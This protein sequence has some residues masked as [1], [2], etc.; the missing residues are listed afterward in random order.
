[1]NRSIASP[2][3]PNLFIVGAPKCGT[4][5]WAEYL[6]S[7][8]DIFFPQHKDQCFFALDLPNF[9]LTRTEADYAELFA[10]SG[11]ASV[12]GEASAMYLFSEVAA[13][14][15]RDHD[16]ASKILIFLREQEDYLPSL[17]NQFLR[18][19]AEEIEDFETVWRLSRQ[20]PSDTIPTTCLEP[21]TLDYVAMGRFREQV[22]RY[23]AAFPP[24]QVRVIQFRDW[25]ANP[26][27]TYLGI[28]DFLGLKDDGRTV[29]PPINQGQTYRSRTLARL[30]IRPPTFARRIARLM[31]NSAL[32][33]WLYGAARAVGFRSAPGYK[34]EIAPELRGEIKRYYAEDNCLL[35][36]RLRQADAPEG[37]HNRN[38]ID[39]A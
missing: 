12:I 4:T 36:K 13:V 10:Q 19:F 39:S 33:R 2:R 15:I 1:M 17:H 21:R 20:R 18:E 28:L 7:H 6:R 37:R 27:A 34:R 30:I 35:E 11:D 32:G 8:P 9:R 14:A 31:K 22:D 23:L 3:L 29:F 38:R 24:E 16:P 25:T 26:R 5:A